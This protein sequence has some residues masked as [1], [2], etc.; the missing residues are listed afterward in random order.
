VDPA[1][2]IE[3]AFNAT[4]WRCMELYPDYLHPNSSMAWI[5]IESTALL[6]LLLSPLLPGV[7]L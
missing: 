1:V 2:S 6:L 5:T 4:V 3:A 7:A